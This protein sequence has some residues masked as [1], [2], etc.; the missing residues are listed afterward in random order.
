MTAKKVFM[1]YCLLYAVAR[2]IATTVYYFKGNQGLQLAVLIIA[3]VTGLIGIAVGI[4]W[5]VRRNVPAVMVRGLLLLYSAAAITNI[6][7]TRA[8][9][10]PH[11]VAGGDL[12][13]IGTLFDLLLLFASLMIPMP[14]V[15][16]SSKAARK[17]VA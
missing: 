16:K 4:R 3:E 8:N 17:P 5:I 1:G 2:F 15:A 6:F 13:I 10:L 12:L 9:P 7:I 11:G 14:D